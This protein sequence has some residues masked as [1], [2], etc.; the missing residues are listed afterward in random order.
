MGEVKIR[1]GDAKVHKRGSAEYKRIMDETG[2]AKKKGKAKP[3]SEA[4]ARNAVK[5]PPPKK[6]PTSIHG[7]PDVALRDRKPVVP[8]GDEAKMAP[9]VKT[10]VADMGLTQAHIDKIIGL[11]PG[12]GMKM[13]GGADMNFKVGETT[14]EAIQDYRSAK[15][16]KALAKKLTMALKGD[17]LGDFGAVKI[18]KRFYVISPNQLAVLKLHSIEHNGLPKG[19]SIL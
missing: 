2:A 13:V 11:I 19:V 14:Y 5:K 18:G 9:P 12:K 1:G 7:E 4:A 8:R 17:G 15:K 3:P 6:P 10:R 16:A